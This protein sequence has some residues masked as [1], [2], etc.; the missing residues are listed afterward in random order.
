MKVLITGATGNVGL[1]LLRALVDQPSIEVVAGVRDVDKDKAQF[2]EL[3]HLECRHFDFGREA[4]FDAALHGIDLVFLLRPP[5]IADIPRFFAPLIQKIKH[6]GIT[7]VVLLSVQGA[8][9]SNIIPHRKIEKLILAHELEY[10][11]L[12]PSYFMENL[13]TTLLPEIKALRTIT[14]PSR[15]AQFNWVSVQDIGAIAANLMVHFETHKNQALVIS[16]NENLSFDE[17]VQRLNRLTGARIRYKSVNPLRY[18]YLKRREGQ[19]RDKVMVMLV[20]HFLPVLQGPPKISDRFQTIMQRKPIL[21][22]Q[23]I[24]DNQRHFLR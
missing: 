5:P 1:A 6:S 24:A 22:E 14:L 20:L 12:R 2:D 8:E 21:L 17:V 7:K 3:K 18:Y 9:R 15:N 11:F 4:T 19:P 10:I 13:T 16:G 23:F